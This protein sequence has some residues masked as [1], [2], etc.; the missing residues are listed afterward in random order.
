MYVVLDG[1]SDFQNGVL[2]LVTFEENALVYGRSLP[3]FGGFQNEPSP[4]GMRLI[5]FGRTAI[6]RLGP[7]R[8]SPRMISGVSDN[9]GIS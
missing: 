8:C 7:P 2:E 3:L 1:D 6:K 9:S 5:K 4:V